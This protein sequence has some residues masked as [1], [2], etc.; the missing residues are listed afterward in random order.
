MAL[1]AWGPLVGLAWDCEG[2][3]R[4]CMLALWVVLLNPNWGGFREVVWSQGFK[5]GGVQLWIIATTM[6]SMSVQNT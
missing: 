1:K 3:D 5:G 6:K 2:F 4:D